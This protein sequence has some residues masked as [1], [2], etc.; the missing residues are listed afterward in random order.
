MT[1]DVGTQVG[2]RLVGRVLDGRYRVGSRIAKGGMATVYEAL[3][4]RLDRSQPRSAH[5]STVRVETP[6]TAATSFLLNSLSS[7]LIITLG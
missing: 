5:R 6:Q 7:A 1:E 2:D 4:M 3:D